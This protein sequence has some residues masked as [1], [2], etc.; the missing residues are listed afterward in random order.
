MTSSIPS[1]ATPTETPRALPWMW[2]WAVAL[3]LVLGLLAAGELT[4]RSLGYRPTVSDSP[5]LWQFWYESAVGA[6]PRTIVLIGSSRMQS[7]ISTSQMRQQL[8]GYRVIQ[9]SKYAGGSPIG[10][11]RK[12]ASDGRF[13]GIV[14]CDTL[15][16]YLIRS[17]WED[18]RQLYATHSGVT[19]RLEAAGL[20]TIRDR[21]AAI[22]V[23]T[24]IKG[25]LGSY[26]NDG[27]LL[28]PD[29]VRM[30]ADRSLEL[31]FTYMEALERFKAKSVADF[32]AIYKAARHP[33]PEDLD[34]DFREINGFVCRIQARGGQVVFVRMPSSGA[35]LALE[36]QF[37]PKAKYW[38]R[39]TAASR[40]VCIHS[41]ELAGTSAFDCPDE[42]H[43]D[44]RNAVKFTGVLVDEMI[45]R[46][47]IT[48]Q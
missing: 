12:L 8:P 23:T 11:L 5:P 3:S 13:N 9:L 40:G 36:E 19:K 14:V 46:Q 44:I 24:G 17:S 43:L 45:R 7:G 27:G 42:S 41:A 25:M 21:I 33:A 38:D 34:D 39:F 28:P 16:P 48:M 30:R 20:A 22:N 29:H 31:D 47:V 2:T 18:Q 6:G 26:L 4:L 10:V 15:T 35:R 32:R 37:H 1:S